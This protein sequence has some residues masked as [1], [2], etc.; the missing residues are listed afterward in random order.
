M[1][2]N[3]LYS[4]MNMLYRKIV[5]LQNIGFFINRIRGR[6]MLHI[7]YDLKQKMEAYRKGSRVTL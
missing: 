2:G 5:M 6:S 3:I 4:Q 7:I 1:I